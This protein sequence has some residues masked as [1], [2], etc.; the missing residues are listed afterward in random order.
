[1]LRFSPSAPV[2]ESPV[3]PRLR[4][5]TSTLLLTATVAA[6]CQIAPHKGVYEDDPLVLSKKPVEG[7][8]RPDAVQLVSSEPAPPPAPTRVFAGPDSIAGSGGTPAHP[9][10]ILKAPIF[11]HP[12]VRVVG[13]STDGEPAVV[14]GHASDLSW[15]QGVL[16]KHY[17][18]YFELR[19]SA[20]SLEERF[21]GK[22]RLED[23]PRLAPFQD[24]DVVRVE[25]L[26]SAAAPGGGDSSPRY[27]VLEIRLIRRMN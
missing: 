20:Q 4:L 5:L 27:K 26:V 11:I 15:A 19:Y 1:M 17:Q 13:P 12:A 6:G 14:F 3:L 22:I 7:T 23:D 18:G 8:P 25:G 24:G 9:V 16:D 2:A 21:S 10:A